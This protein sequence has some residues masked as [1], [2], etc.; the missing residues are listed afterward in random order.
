MTHSAAVMV[1][2]MLPG[3]PVRQWMLSFP[4]PSVLLFVSRPKLMT[5]VLGIAYRVIPMHLM[6]PLNIGETTTR[7]LYGSRL[8]TAIVD[9][10]PAIFPS[11]SPNAMSAG[12]VLD[13]GFW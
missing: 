9:H 12:M 3:Q 13:G 10:W 8:S 4:Y 7:I 6:K 2:E 11:V 1:D 5:Q